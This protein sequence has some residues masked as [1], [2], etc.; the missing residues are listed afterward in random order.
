MKKLLLF[1]TIFCFV[2]AQEMLIYGHVY[3]S[4]SEDNE[5]TP[6]SYAQVG[7]GMDSVPEGTFTFTNDEG[8][9][10]LIFDWYW[11]GPIPI[12][13]EAV[14]YEFFIETIMPN[15]TQIEFN[16]QLN[17]INSDE[18]C[19]EEECGPPPMMPN[20]LCSDGITIA[21]PGDCI[22]SA[23]GECFWEMIE[24]PTIL[25]YLR[26]IETSDCQDACSQYYIEPEI[27]DGFGVIPI[28]FQDSNININ[29]YIN[30]FVEFDL[31]QEVTCVECSAFEVVELIISQ[32]CEFPIACFVDPCDVEEECQINIPIDCLSNYCGG[33]NADFYDFDGNLVDCNTT[34]E[35]CFDFTGINFGEC[36]MVLGV[37][38]INSECNFISGCNWTIDGIDYSDLIFDTIEECEIA[39]E[40]G[41]SI[42]LGDINGDGDIN[43]LDI[44]LLVG[45][46]LQTDSPSDF[47]LIAADFN[48]DNVLNVLDVVGIITMIL[49]PVNSI[50]INSGITYGLCWGYCL[51]ELELTNSNSVF[52]ASSG[53]SEWYDE[54]LDILLTDNLNQEAWQ[55]LINLI[56]IEYFQSLDDVYGC[57]DCADGGAEFIEII[58]DGVAKQV[59]FEAY[60]E[61]DGIQDLTIL[62]R[63]LRSDYWNQINENQECYNIPE[64]GPC[65]GVCSTYYYNQESNVCEDFMFGCCGPEAFNTMEECINSCE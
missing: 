26:E 38:Y 11:D 42:D 14:N 58:Y 53:A 52:T 28:I 49:N 45:F 21:G 10:E 12:V 41:N 35:E 17:P 2:G 59:T 64:V 23:N 33:C 60:T 40:N 62:L 3:S 48:E 19:T 18:E 65:D 34:I 7:I 36:A 1:I 5:I 22:E 6:I 20:Y 13:C 50:Q 9:Y 63:E 55:Q 39:C 61:I 56:D 47:E 32:D 25:G 54:F 57:P 29:L 4:I 24:C 44:V 37:A 27:D 16:I 43:V 31:G 51:F 30:R 8:Y 15:N 46:I